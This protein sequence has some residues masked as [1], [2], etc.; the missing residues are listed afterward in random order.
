VKPGP[1]QYLPKGSDLSAHSQHELDLIA[2]E[3]NRRPRKTLEWM[4]PAER[5]LELLG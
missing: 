5:M 4:K 2:D 3:L 1:A